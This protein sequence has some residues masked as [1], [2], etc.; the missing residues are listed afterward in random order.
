M[1]NTTSGTTQSISACAFN[2][3][4][5]T[6]TAVDS[7]DGAVKTYPNTHKDYNKVEI[8]SIASM[9][10]SYAHSA[11]AG[12]NWDFAYDIWINGIGNVG[13]STE[14][15][16]WTEAKGKQADAVKGYS[17]VATAT[18]GG[19]SYDIKKNGNT[20]IVYNMSTYK[21]SGTVDLKAIMSDMITRGLIPA[22]STVDQVDYG[23]EIVDSG[24]ANQLFKLTNFS[25]TP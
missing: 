6:S 16:I 24:G 4:V 23:V 11:P 2:N 14:L 13:G 15:M 25:V 9:T 17:S 19:T 7:G 22:N 20:Y 1:W 3:W 8:S 12:G 5:V 10:S 21:N 18:L